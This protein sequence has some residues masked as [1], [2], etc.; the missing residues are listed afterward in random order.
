[1]TLASVDTS[2]MMGTAPLLMECCLV[3]TRSKC[4]YL[5]LEGIVWQGSV[6]T[7]A[8]GVLLCAGGTT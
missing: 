7:N 8:S 1:M 6:A 2:I 5:V 4:T 3:V